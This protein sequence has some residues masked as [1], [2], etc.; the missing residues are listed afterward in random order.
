MH[1]MFDAVVI[2]SGQA[3]PS[4]A[5]RLAQA[6]EKVALVEQTHLGGTCVNDGCMPTKTMVASAR[7]AHL[8]RRAA[9]FGVST[10]GPITVDMPAVIARKDAIV[11]GAKRNLAA[12]LDGIDNLELIWGTAKFLAPDVIDAGGR[13]LQA[14]RIFI[15]TGGRAAIPDW[16][17]LHDVP[18]LTNTTLME[19]TTLPRHLIVAGGSY[20]GLEFAQMYRR[21]GA[22]VTVIEY[23]PDIIAREDPDVRAAL[24]AILQAE[25]IVIH[26]G[27][28]DIT[29]A[30]TPSGVRLQA[31]ASGNALHLE[32]SHLLLAVGR[33]PNTEALDLAAAGIAPD[34][35]GFIRVD[36]SLRT[37]VE[38]IWALGDVHGRGAFTHTSYND[39]E[40]VAANLLDGAQR[41]I[42]DR[43][44]AYALFTDPP[45]ARIGMSDTE[46]AAGGR[47]IL[48]GFM[49]M[50][51]VG[52]AKERG[53]TAGFMK[54]LVDAGTD[55][56]LGATLL[57]I[58][59]DEV[60]H[61]LLDIM[62]AD[63]P[64]TAIRRCVHIHPTVSE[65]IPTMLGDLQ[66]WPVLA[67][68]AGGNAKSL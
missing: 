41:R 59:A 20:I 11:Q 29:V 53:E 50:S 48:R 25:G 42:T 3:G 26:T 65:L 56:I 14:R 35:R 54:V 23:A 17:G 6:G 63:A 39:Y 22:E 46:A 32:G 31:Q 10:G 4:L 7:V 18:Y 33:R 60:I 24:R 55:R 66:P 28:R 52:R 19:L 61:A 64:Y 9:D 67:A 15:N 21:F 47:K 62:S 68:A 36:D 13:T 49:P 30:R 37:S 44:L 34:A 38:T 27:V 16:P 40:I 57:C 51:R 5:A 12:W 1:E 2:G 45:L 8:A 58:E 43:I